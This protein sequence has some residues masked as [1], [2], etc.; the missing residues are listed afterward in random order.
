[1]LQKQ[2]TTK[3][4]SGELDKVYEVLNKTIGERTGVHI[5]FP[6]ID[7]LLYENKISN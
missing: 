6:S 1:M 5:D 4:E 7:Q 2:S 3:L